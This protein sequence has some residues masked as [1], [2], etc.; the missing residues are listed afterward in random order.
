V[1][2][3]GLGARGVALIIGGLAVTAGLV[4]L[5][6]S[7]HLRPGT[8]FALAGVMVGAAAM[9]LVPVLSPLGLLPRP[10]PA[11]PHD[12]GGLAPRSPASTRPAPTVTRVPPVSVSASHT[13]QDSTDNAGNPVSFSA[14]NLTD[15]DLATAWRVPGNGVGEDI[16]VSFAGQV[17]LRRIDI[18]AGYTK[19]DPVTGEDRFRQN[20]RLERVTLLFGD[21]SE[22]H[23]ALDPGSEQPQ[24]ADLDVATS[25][26]TVRIDA[27]T[28]A[29]LDY[30]AVSEIQFWAQQD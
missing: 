7:P 19:H 23:V 26:V 11:L 21:G 1:L 17:H 20:R 4:M 22:Q 12:G 28:S 10:S 24:P 13:A 9:L 6:T 30:T 5:V 3:A 2:A 8:G 14:R 16:G 15:G 18:T 25:T 29:P 27:T